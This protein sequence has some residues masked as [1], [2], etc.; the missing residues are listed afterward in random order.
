MKLLFSFLLSVFL[1]GCYS[2][3]P[4][5][6]GLEGKPLP[7]F[8]LLL[9]DSSTYLNTATIP[10]GHPIAL[11]FYGPYCPYSRAQMEIIL[12]NMSELKDVHFYVFTSYPFHDMK[13]FYDDYQLNKYSN[14]T[15]GIDYKLVFSNYYQVPGVPYLAVYDKNKLLKQAFIGQVYSKQIKSAIEE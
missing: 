7:S 3:E 12:N 5:K 14:I 10:S 4:L 2:K 1:L 15:A 8:S 6:T 9:P 11:F 13:K